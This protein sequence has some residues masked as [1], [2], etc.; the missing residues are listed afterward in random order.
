MRVVMTILPNLVQI[1]AERQGDWAIPARRADT[2]T[3][4][5]FGKQL[6]GWDTMRASSKGKTLLLQSKNGSSILPARS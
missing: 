1:A 5:I 2:I 6:A 4:S 3:V